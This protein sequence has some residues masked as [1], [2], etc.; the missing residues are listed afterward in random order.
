MEHDHINWQ[1][2]PLIHRPRRT[3]SQKWPIRTIHLWQ[4][5]EV[6][7]VKLSDYNIQKWN[8]MVGLVWNDGFMA[9]RYWALFLH[10]NTFLTILKL[11]RT[12]LQCISINYMRSPRTL[13]SS[14][15]TQLHFRSISRN[16]YICVVKRIHNLPFFYT[17]SNLPRDINKHKIQINIIYIDLVSLKNMDP[18]YK[19]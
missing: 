17:Y 6:L 5:V 16:S 13:N 4:Y 11:S 10:L 1:T 9:C 14:T 18:I 8:G 15:S 2:T 7:G 3:P 19:L 12:I